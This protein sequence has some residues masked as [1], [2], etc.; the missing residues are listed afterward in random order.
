METE[1]SETLTSE[2]TLLSPPLL[3]G[4]R[5]PSVNELP[6][7]M[8]AFYQNANGDRD[9]DEK[10]MSKTYLQSTLSIAPVENQVA[11]DKNYNSSAMLFLSGA[12]GN[13]NNSSADEHMIQ[14]H[15]NKTHVKIAKLFQTTVNSNT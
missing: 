3:A 12:D 13:Q 4:M 7:A 8:N 9:Q 6:G 10:N 15:D 5:S 14:D 1:L 2:P 11:S